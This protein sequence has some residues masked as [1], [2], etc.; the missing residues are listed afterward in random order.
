MC[1]LLLP[2]VGMSTPGARAVT[3]AVMRSFEP[4]SP[5]R[6][7]DTRDGTGGVA[8]RRLAD[9]EV[10]AF[11]V[12]GRRGLPASGIGS[13]S[14]NVAVTGTTAAGFVTVYPCDAPRPLTS[15]LNHGA[16]STVSNAVIAPVAADGRVCFHAERSTH[17]V[18]DVSG[19]FPVGGGFN[20][21]TP[22]RSFDTRTG[23]GGVPT[24]RVGSGGLS[25]RFTGVH[26]V[27]STGVSAVSFNLTATG[28]SSTGFITA[29]PCD[30]NRPLVSSLGYR[31]RNTVG[32]AVVSPVAAD[33]RVCFH[34]E[35]PVHL[36]ADVNGWFDTSGGFVPVTPRRLLDTRTTPVMN[37]T[38]AG[39][40]P[41][42]TNGEGIS[43]STVPWQVRLSV[44][45]QLLCGGSIV[46]ERWILTAAHCV[47]DDFGQAIDPT[48]VRVW[49]GLSLLSS[50]NS[51]NAT[52]ADEVI[53]HPGFNRFTF[54]NDIALVRL[55][56][57]LGTGTVIP[58]WTDPTGPVGLS[59]AYVSGWGSR[60][61]GAGAS[62]Q[63]QGASLRI[64]SG[65]GLPCGSWQDAYDPV[66]MV[67]A[68]G[69][70]SVPDGAG[71]CTGDS[72]GPLVVP[73]P[74]S[75]PRLVGVVSFGYLGCLNDHAYPTVFSRVSAF[76]SWIRK[77]VPTTG[78]VDDATITLEVTGRAGVPA[79]GVG[80]VI[81][82]VSSV[83]A[84][85]PG[86][87]TV[88]PC[89]PRP[90]AANVNSATGR[91][92]QNLVVAPVSAAGTVCLYSATAAHL[93]V[94]V[95]GWVPS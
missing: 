49:G 68:S 82:T 88:F 14:L 28:A 35:R 47:V 71:A 36:I 16:R 24:G 79:T 27:P 3:P 20:S 22:R 31:A 41:F 67:C 43:I 26:G 52:A 15:N 81:L 64:R 40:V 9:G 46:H 89:G 50:M 6:L 73:G 34:A 29:Y 69:G 85:A 55:A 32:S 21:V 44:S 48:A 75:S 95:S 72:G 39:P 53:V 92:V 80:A 30:V 13:V 51:F 91:V 93:V 2:V 60:T 18:V 25:Y 86:Y 94:E 59:S 61:G 5:A 56:A 17:L 78:M 83:N 23:S 57:P 33:G 74:G 65:P 63:L 37:N 10:L 38:V 76:V 7:L 87:V 42:V 90:L 54:V 77:Y 12:R 1:A 84:L 45:G 11:D 66:T 4:V 19:W 70:L 62:E 8:R 58:L